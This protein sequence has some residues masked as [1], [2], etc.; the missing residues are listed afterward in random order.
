MNIRSFV[1]LTA[2]LAA[3]PIA[4]HADSLLGAAAAY[5][6]VALGTVDAQGNTVIAGNINTQADI[7]G[8]IAAANMVLSGT[9]VGSAFQNG[10]AADPFGSSGSYSIVAGNGVASGTTFNIN[11]GGNVYDP[12]GN[13]HFNL[14]KGGTTIITSGPSPIDFSSLRTSMD[15][16]TLTL[17]ALMNTGTVGAPTP[18]NGNPSWFV[19]SGTSATLNIFTITA[20]EFASVNNP[21]DIQVP[22]GSTVIIN[23]DG[24]NV[25]LG[26]GIYLNGTQESDQN[27]DGGDI[28]FNFADATSVAIDGQLD[29]S[30]LAPFAT[31]TGNSQMGGTFIAAAI[32]QTGEV[33]NLEFNGTVPP[34]DPTPPAV[35]EPAS[36][37]LLGTGIL[38]LAGM[39]RRKIKG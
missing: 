19:L 29:G 8:R 23:V 34:T 39:L 27:N 15:S 31:L 7:T 30:V 9:T 32:G 16:E 17:A 20:A 10:G 18:K 2:T 25:T 36:L 33:H 11:G 22:A 12:G 14:N 24:T 28:L 4:C 35:P 6:L 5:N 3:L 26:A 37:T 1:V 21:I 13:G 38:G